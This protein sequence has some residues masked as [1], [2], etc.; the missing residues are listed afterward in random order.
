MKK[1]LSA[2][3][4]SSTM[5]CSTTL[6]NNFSDVPTDSWYSAAVT[7]ASEAGYISGYEDG[8]YKPNEYLTG[9]QWAVILSNALYPNQLAQEF[10]RGDS[11]SWADPYI[12]T[13][14]A[15]ARDNSAV[16]HLNFN[17]NITRAQ[18]ASLIHDG[19]IPHMLSM[20]MFEEEWTEILNE[21]FTHWSDCLP[22]QDGVAN[23][24]NYGFMTGSSEDSFGGQEPLNRAQAAVIIVNMMESRNFSVEV[25]EAIPYTP[26]MVVDP[27]TY[28][29][30]VL[31]DIG[32]VTLGYKEADYPDYY[33]NTLRYF[34]DT[35]EKLGYTLHDFDGDGQ[36]ELVIGENREYD[37]K[38][39]MAF[40]YHNGEVK[41]L[42]VSH[43]REH[44]RFNGY[45]SFFMQGSGSAF[46]GCYY[47][48]TIENSQA[49]Y[50][51]PYYIYEYDR[52]GISEE[53][54]LLAYEWDGETVQ[55]SK[56]RV[57]TQG[58][59]DALYGKYPSWEDEYAFTYTPFIQAPQP[60]SITEAAA[61]LITENWLYN[62]Y[63]VYCPLN[64]AVSLEYLSIDK[65]SR[66]PY[67]HYTFTNQNHT[68][69][70]FLHG[71]SGSLHFVE[72]GQICTVDVWE[73]NG[74]PK[75]FPKG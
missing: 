23:V 10:T 54:V 25:L 16:H 67:Y 38:F 56:V 24:L 66:E 39:M 58:E 20:R 61:K 37:S 2:L 32:E 18:A 72:S 12:N 75:G 9:A 70:L 49:V 35:P 1:F 7:K 73:A 60:P 44:A 65:G 43:E 5:L 6:A 31:N 48:I 55:Y 19:M 62:T 29:Q 36:M 59:I 68:Y 26:P 14:S 17:Q 33:S 21:H 45:S 71:H 22:Y 64:D 47:E 42:V 63:P 69:D 46:D 53:P 4:L 13:V 8:T 57:A 40:G 11:S 30:P 52:E 34:N 41:P 3:L 28:F 50:S 51:S 15:Y 27:M 74:F